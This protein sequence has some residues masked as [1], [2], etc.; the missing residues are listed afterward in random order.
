MP[1]DALFTPVRL[2]ALPLAHR[3]V[4]APLTRMRSTL[5]GNVPNAVMATYYGQRASRG[6]LIIT[7]ATDVSAQAAGYPGAPGVHSPE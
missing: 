1:A 4:M 5:P 6:G 3:V 2:G 7:E